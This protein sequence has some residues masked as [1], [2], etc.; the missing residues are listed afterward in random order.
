M[1]GLGL[2]SVFVKANLA[3]PRHVWWYLKNSAAACWPQSKTPGTLWSWD[4]SGCRMWFQRSFASKGQSKK[5]RRPSGAGVRPLMRFRDRDSTTRKCSVGAMNCRPKQGKM[6]QTSGPASVWAA[7]QSASGFRLTAEQCQGLHGPVDSPKQ[8]DGV[9]LTP[10]RKEEQRGCLQLMR[11]PPGRVA[12]QPCPLAT[13]N[14]CEC[15][16]FGFHLL[17]HSR[18][19]GM[20]TKARSS[21]ECSM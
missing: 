1:Q 3:P 11:V 4:I 10:R 8:G 13:P 6:S 20:G 18:G 19:T 2:H 5:Q 17:G 14:H 21:A 12:G 15:M 7:L 16:C 9:T